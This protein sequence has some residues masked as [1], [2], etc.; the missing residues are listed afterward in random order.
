MDIN[1]NKRPAI[2]DNQKTPQDQP[3]THHR[4]YIKL[5]RSNRGKYTVLPQEQNLKQTTIYTQKIDYQRWQ[6]HPKFLS[7]P[8]G[9]SY[10]KDGSYHYQRR[11]VICIHYLDQHECKIRYVSF[12][13]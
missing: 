4:S 3:S 13:I 11:Q 5:G 8:A 12:I 6:P 10:M 1:T 2:L 9:E 7:N